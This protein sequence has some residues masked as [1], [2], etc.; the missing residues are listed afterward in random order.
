MNYEITSL[1][2]SGKEI[3]QRVMNASTSQ[4]LLP[5]RLVDQEL[6]IPEPPNGHKYIG[7]FSSGTTGNPKCIWNRYDHL[8]ENA[9]Y[10]ATAFEVESAQL[11]LMM[12]MPWHV[13]GLSWML[14][15]EY[16][17]VEYV[18]VTTQKGEEEKWKQVAKNIQPDYLFTVPAVL[19]ALY[20]EKWFIPNVAYGGYPIKVKE[21][22]KI[23]PHCTNIYQGYGQTE[24]GGLIS[25][26]KKKSITEPFEFENLCQGKPIEGVKLECEGNKKTPEPILIHSKTAYISGVYDSG[27]VGYKDRN[28]NIYVVGRS[29]QSSKSSSNSEKEL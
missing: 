12:A 7:L 2:G 5:P 25:V 21:F 20:K 13:A 8:V 9:K 15:S 23:A 6:I 14:M 1:K 28:G 24:A 10:S 3:I 4:L 29:L 26:H 16:L 17:E 19:R 11:I 18:F 27:D 22:E